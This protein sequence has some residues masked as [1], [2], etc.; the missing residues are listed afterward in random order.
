M[1]KVVRLNKYSLDILRE[2]NNNREFFNKSN[3]EFFSI[4]DNSNFPSQIFIRRRVRLLFKGDVAIGYVWIEPYEKD[5]NKIKA[6]YIEGDY[7]E[8]SIKEAYEFLLHSLPKK[9]IYIYSCLQNDLNEKLLKDLLFSLKGAT[10]TLK[11]NIEDYYDTKFQPIEREHISTRAFIRD[12]DEELRCKIQ[13]EIFKNNKRIPLSID[14][15]YFDEAQEYY[16]EEGALFLYYKE[17]C[18]GYGQLMLDHEKPLIV[19]FGLIEEYR[20]SGFSKILM[21]L[22]LRKA[23]MLNYKECFIKVSSSNEKALGLY[24]SSGFTIHEEETEYYYFT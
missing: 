21:N 14:D 16:I 22:L 4:Y 9:K 17:Q 24:K 1:Y 3:E 20:G 23:A 7:K 5:V 19:N 18:I 13:N 8:A 2:L 10:I 11:R 6:L 12:K 15:I